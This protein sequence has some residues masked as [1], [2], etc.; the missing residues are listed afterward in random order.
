MKKHHTKIPPHI[1]Q[2][3]I[4]YH[5][6]ICTEIHLH[7][8]IHKILPQNPAK[9]LSLLFFTYAYHHHSQTSVRIFI[10]NLHSLWNHDKSETRFYQDIQME[11]L[12]YTWWNILRATVTSY[13]APAY[14]YYVNS[15]KI[16]KPTHISLLYL[17]PPDILAAIDTWTSSFE[18]HDKFKHVISRFK[19]MSKPV[20]FSIKS[21]YW[22]PCHNF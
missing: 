17:R 7:T 6:I 4:Q 14:N 5:K 20:I 19:Y 1:T 18:Y 16:L 11:T 3:R 12:W 2:F 22:N 13:R 21:K 10:K 15:Y 9:F 8:L